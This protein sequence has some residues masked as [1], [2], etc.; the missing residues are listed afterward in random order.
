MSV[1]EFEG[2]NEEE[3]INKAIES[4]ALDRDEIDVEI[5]EARKAPI[6]FGGGRVR[7]RV[8]LEEE[9]QPEDNR[10]Y[11]EI[12]EQGQPRER[13]G[14]GAREGRGQ[15]GAA[16]APPVREPPREPLPA[17]GQFEQ[18]MVDYLQGLV[19]RM[20]IPGRVGICFL[21]AGTDGNDGPTDA[22]GAFASRGLARECRSQGL[23]PQAYLKEND[24][25][26]LYSRIGGLLKTGPTNTNVSDIQLLI[27]A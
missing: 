18:A 4:L 1:K 8:H 22:A 5:E 24:S 17:E 27:V 3:A 19:E 2:K 9:R 15:R 10:S 23:D 26:T 12:Q 14:R 11:H 20:G 25:Y 7:I 21:S 13:R 6:L 16:A